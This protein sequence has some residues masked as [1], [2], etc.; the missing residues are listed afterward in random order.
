MGVQNGGGF[1]SE[2]YLLAPSREFCKDLHLSSVLEA[3]P[4]MPIE[5][6]DSKKADKARRKD[7]KQE[8]EMTRFG[9]ATSMQSTIISMRHYQSKGRGNC[10]VT[11]L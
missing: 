6:L 1:E 3:L 10:L 11:L 7:S 4:A 5:F 9:A 8:C 2:P